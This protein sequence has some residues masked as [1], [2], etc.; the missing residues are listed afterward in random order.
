MNQEHRMISTVDRYLFLEWSK[1]FFLT[2]G[3]ILGV[4]IL[5]D[6]YDDL[7][8]L[9]SYGA[10]LPAILVYYLVLLPSFIPL[11][12]PIGF[13]VSLL[14]SV[15]TFH[16]NNEI[17]ALRSSGQSLWRISRSL[18]LAGLALSLLLLYL[19]AWAV[20]WSIET[21]REF[22]DTLRFANEAAT[23][24]I[25]SEVG[26]VDNL[27]FDNASENR[28]WFMNQFSERAYL[29]LGV[30]V[31]NRD[32]RGREYYRIMAREGVYDEARGYWTFLEG[33]EM[34][35]TDTGE[36]LRSVAF[37]RLEKPVY[38]E[39]PGLMLALNKRPKD[40]SLFEISG[41][42]QRVSAK[43]NPRVNAYRVQYYEILA[44]PFSCL[45]MVGLAIPF[46]VAGVRTNPMVGVSKSIGYFLLFYFLANFFAILGER[47]IL[48]PWFAAGFPYLLML[49]VGMVFFYRQR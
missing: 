44:G 31:Y 26:L 46:A 10:E 37:D 14:I 23:A 15:G 7:P 2:L 32:A 49:L 33:R 4:L 13:L 3:V 27:S 12:L 29:G 47:Q 41:I 17:V 1:V 25:G 48:V 36:P 9:L 40:L 35:F 24:E 22:S 8:D 11:V 19:N 20:P 28:L 18:A 30:T 43:D 45:I 39:D 34:T 16:K 5:E 6:M 38:T 42:L 21:S